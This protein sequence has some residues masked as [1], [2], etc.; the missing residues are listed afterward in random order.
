MVKVPTVGM[1]SDG[2]ADERRKIIDPDVAWP[3]AKPGDPWPFD[4]AG[5]DI[6]DTVQSST[7]FHP[8]VA[9]IPQMTMRMIPA[10]APLEDTSSVVTVDKD[11]NMVALTMTMTGMLGSG[12]TVPGTGIALNNAM[13]LFHPTES[14]AQPV[15]DHPNRLQ[16]GKLA[17]GN[18]S[19]YI[20]M[21]DGK[22]F[23]GIAGAGGRRIMT[24][25][26][27]TAVRVID[28]NMDVQDAVSAPRFH[29]EQR[30]PSLIEAAFPYGIAKELEA[31]G[32]TLQPVRKWGTVFA[33][34]ADPQ[35]G[36]YHVS[37]EW[38]SDGA[39]AGVSA[40]KK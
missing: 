35:T 29:V 36:S 38:R 24:E 10:A 25:V 6:F 20:V 3:Y 34:L 37:R 27:E 32:H 40:Q 28:W 8:I 2:Y 26:L 22:P 39:N 1:M 16:G 13:G 11:G 17:L 21:R 18:V 31:K 33:I 23:L 7:P 14:D 30:E 19:S 9:P 15:P 4:T 12:V 5:P